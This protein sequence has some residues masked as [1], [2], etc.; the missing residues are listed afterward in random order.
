MQ[1]GVL[2]H[3]FNTTENLD[4]V[5]PYSEPK[6][7]GADYMSGDERTRILEWY[8]EQK[9]KISA[10]SRSSWPTALMMSMY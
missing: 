9:E 5:S 8:E 2:N 10:I 1:E 4:F 3:F 7:Y 6:F